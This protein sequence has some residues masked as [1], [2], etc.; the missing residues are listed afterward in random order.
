[1]MPGQT[2]PA[3]MQNQSQ[4]GNN[5]NTKPKSQPSKNMNI[6]F[7]INEC[8]IGVQGKSNMSIKQLIKNFKIKLCNNKIEIEKYIALPDKIELDPNSEETLA[9]KNI[10]EKT[11]IQAIPKQNE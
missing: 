6:Q 1:M 10:T 2:M 8:L 5:L 3:E 9:S 11:T 7:C 4:G